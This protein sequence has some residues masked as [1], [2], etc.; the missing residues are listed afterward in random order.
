MSTELGRAVLRIRAD[1][2]NFEV[3]G[4]GSPSL[5]FRDS[6]EMVVRKSMFP[7]HRTIMVRA[8]RAAKDIPREMLGLLRNPEQRLEIEIELVQR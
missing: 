6:R 8:D 4:Q 5:T 7:S 2:K 3:H 1:G